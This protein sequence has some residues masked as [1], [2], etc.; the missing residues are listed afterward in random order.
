MMHDVRG[1][2]STLSQVGIPRQKEGASLTRPFSI[3]AK[4]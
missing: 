1:E 4:I 2:L 3:S